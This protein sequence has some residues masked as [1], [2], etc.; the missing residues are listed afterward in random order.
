MSAHDQTLLPVAG[1]SR[2]LSTAL[3]R[4][5]LHWR[6]CLTQRHRYDQL[7]LEHVHG[8]PFVVL[9]QVFN[10][11]L[12]RTG[13]FLAGKLDSRLIPSGSSVLDMG[14]G[15]GVTAIFAA[16][17]ARR[18][19]AV[20]IN[21][22]AVRCARINALLNGLDERVD[23]REGDLFAPVSGERFD[24]VLFNP[25]YFRGAPRDPLDHAWRS[26]DVVERFASG[27]R[28]HLTPGGSALVV[29]S[30]D[31]DT[32]AFLAA[33]ASSGLV[34]SVVARTALINETLTIYRLSPM[35]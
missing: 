33:F 1:V 9:P 22:H 11:R 3:G 24:V 17:F 20:D 31:G 21:P 2:R 6:Y 19:V 5:W 14:T 8:Q 35:G 23:V 15:S 34:V 16:H 4:R 28:E 32:P 25:P 30:T 10:P 18:V 29:L 27:L 12:F 26:V 7:V 13:E